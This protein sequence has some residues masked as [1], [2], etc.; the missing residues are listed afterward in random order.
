MSDDY[1]FRKDS[2]LKHRIALKSDN[3]YVHRSHEAN[4]FW[5]TDIGKTPDDT[6]T[7]LLMP[8]GKTDGVIWYYFFIAD[9][10]VDPCWTIGAKKGD[11]LSTHP[12]AGDSNQQFAFED[13]GDGKVYIQNKWSGLYLYR[14]ALMD[15]HHA[16]RQAPKEDSDKFKFQIKELS[17]VVM[18]ATANPDDHPQPSDIGNP[19]YPQQYGDVPLNPDKVLV[20][21]TLT[22]FYMVGSDSAC[23]GYN[24]RGWQIKN[25]PYYRL[26]R[27]QQWQADPSGIINQPDIGK[28]TDEIT[29]THGIKEQSGKEMQDKTSFM[30]GVDIGSKSEMGVSFDGITAKTETT[31]AFKMQWQ[32]EVTV[33]T[34]GY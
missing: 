8:A 3:G 27:E 24:L 31:R 20:G 2:K 4:F 19:P 5:Y 22:P 25:R 6:E 23:V 18:P 30:V 34:T 9:P 11:K 12:F 1:D 7:F 29:E 13:A 10:K 32:H 21:E 15:A 14:G 16:V 17:Q 26:R 28:R 33:T